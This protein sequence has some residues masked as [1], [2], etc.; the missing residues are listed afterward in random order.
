[1]TTAITLAVGDEII[2]RCNHRIA[3][4]DGTTTV[5]RIGMTGRIIASRRRGVTVDLDPGRQA[6]GSPASVT[7]PAAHVGTH[8]DY[9]YDRGMREPR[10]R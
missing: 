2:L 4:P 8:V 7:L 5:V 6:P 1:M 10:M 3:Q 9:G